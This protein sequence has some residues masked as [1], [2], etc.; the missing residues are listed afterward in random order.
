MK[1]EVVVGPL[2]VLVLW[3]L[4]NALHV[5]KPVFLPSI[6]RVFSELYRLFATGQILGDLGGTVMRWIIG[7]AVGVCIGVPLGMLMGYSD[8]VY[9]SLEIVVDFFRSVPAM[10]LFPLFLVFFGL[11][12]K[13]KISIAAWG[14]LLYVMVSAMYGVKHSRHTRLMV[15]KTLRATPLQ[16]FTK[17]VFP[18]ALPE[19]AGGMR[20]AISLSLVL[21]VASEMMMGTSLGLG[22]RILDASLVYNM[23]QMY[24]TIIVAGLVGY[25]SNKLFVLLESKLIHWAGR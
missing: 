23:S 10:T 21:V 11:G 19:I 5:V 16:T 8:R 15:A 22:K 18:D 6:D 9:G 3:F 25:I 2:L 14:S 4:L 1:K 24:A 7:L 20:V 17:F 12:D 13:A